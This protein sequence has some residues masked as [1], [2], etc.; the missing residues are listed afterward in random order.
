MKRIFILL[1]LLPLFSLGQTN[2]LRKTIKEAL[3]DKTSKQVCVTKVIPD[4]LTAITIA[5]PI[6]FKIYG[7]AQI[8][9]EKPYNVNLI[10]DYWVLEGSLPKG[11]VGGTFFIILSSKDG[12]VIKLI[13]YK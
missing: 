8:I 13:H 11:Y 3:A 6:L 9:S 12:R 4:K 10:D 7:K 2:E 1:L 5:E